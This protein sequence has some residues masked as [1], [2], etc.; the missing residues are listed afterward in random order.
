MGTVRCSVTELRNSQGNEERKENEFSG[1]GLKP[2]K[3]GN[4]TRWS[5]AKAKAKGRIHAGTKW[6]KQ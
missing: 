5:R 4:R 2:N 3:E 1:A 6:E